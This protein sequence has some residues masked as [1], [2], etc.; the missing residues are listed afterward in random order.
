[1]RMCVFYVAP[2]L[3]V[4][5]NAVAADK[6]DETGVRTIGRVTTWNELLQVEPIDLGDGVRIRL[7]LDL[8]IQ[9]TNRRMNSSCF[10]T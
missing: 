9:M 10:L 4:G 7:G 3:L 6:S 5:G 1:M 2:L 8:P